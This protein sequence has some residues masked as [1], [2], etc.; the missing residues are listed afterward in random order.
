MDTARLRI[1][2]HDLTHVLKLTEKHSP[3]N[4]KLLCEE[5]IKLVNKL[6]SA[7]HQ[8]QGSNCHDSEAIIAEAME[9]IE[10]K[11]AEL[12]AV[13]EDLG[14]TAERYE[15]MRE[16]RDA[17]VAEAEGLLEHPSDRWVL[18][19]SYE[20]MRELAMRP[21]AAHTVAT[22]ILTLSDEEAKC[23]ANCAAS[24]A[25]ARLRAGKP[26]SR[27][28]GIRARLPGP[29]DPAVMIIADAVAPLR[30]DDVIVAQQAQ[31]KLLKDGASALTALVNAIGDALGCPPGRK[32]ADVLAAAQAREYEESREAETG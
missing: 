25:G 13:H 10:A 6:Q 31:I 14:R 1:L 8:P 28:D 5:T 7:F 12:D 21:K 23:L 19:E 20:Q 3:F 27:I 16:Q 32:P 17:A 11:A 9:L 30:N 29:T 22:H 4:Q 2:A 24:Y 26:T 18:R 15:E